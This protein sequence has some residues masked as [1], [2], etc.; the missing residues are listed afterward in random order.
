MKYHPACFLHVSCSQTKEYRYPVFQPRPQDL[1]I[2]EP[3]LSISQAGSDPEFVS[4]WFAQS[5]LGCGIGRALM[6][7]GSMV[8]ITSPKSGF[9]VLVWLWLE[10]ASLVRTTG[11]CPV[12]GRLAASGFVVVTKPVFEVGAGWESRFVV[13]PSLEVQVIP[14]V[15]EDTGGGLCT[16]EL[17]GTGKVG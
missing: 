2:F 11:P 10:V 14:S 1:L 8:R 3:C 16:C 13:L 15:G 17:G 7:W 9:F 5:L 6:I 12:K 4:R